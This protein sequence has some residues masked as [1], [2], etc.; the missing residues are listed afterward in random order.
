MRKYIIVAV[1][2]T[3][4]LGV[5]FFSNS[6]P[7]IKNYP[8]K[9]DTIVAFG[10]S[11][12]R[13]V[14]ATDG[15]GFVY[16][17]SQKLGKPI[18][19][20]GVSGDTTKEGLARINEAI[21][22]NPGTVVLLLGGNDYLKKVPQEETFNNLRQIITKFQSGGSMVVLLGVRGGVLSDKFEKPFENLARETGSIYVSDVLSGVITKKEYMYDTV[23][24]NDEGYAIIADRIYQKVAKYI[25]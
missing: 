3:F 7:I 18:V 9:N 4:A 23:H 17:L 2:A 19:N 14:G 16:L 21:K 20:L 24:P 5:Y 22:K 1:L 13:G 10:D 25:K 6:S 15:K 11:L 12:T 8:P